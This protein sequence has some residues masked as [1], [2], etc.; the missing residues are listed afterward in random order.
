MPQSS[1]DLKSMTAKQKKAFMQHY[2]ELQKK[3]EDAAK[4]Y[5]HR[6]D[7]Q[8]KIHDQEDIIFR[9]NAHEI[10]AYKAAHA[11]YLAA[12][13]KVEHRDSDHPLERGVELNVNKHLSMVDQ[14]ALRPLEKNNGDSFVA[15]SMAEDITM[16]KQ[17]INGVSKPEEFDF[18]QALISPKR[19]YIMA[20]VYEKIDTEI[21]S[22]INS[23]LPKAVHKAEI[24]KK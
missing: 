15:L 17:G 1:D 14:K 6:P 22:T 23:H 19:Q 8:K 13:A 20:G 4:K 12:I 11:K 21:R 18:I 2:D 9:E 16:N 7:E 5:L 3:L 10:K 24:H